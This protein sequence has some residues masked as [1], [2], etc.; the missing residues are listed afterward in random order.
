MFVLAGDLLLAESIKGLHRCPRPV[1]QDILDVV[2]QMTRATMLEAIYSR[3]DGYDFGSISIH[4]KRER[5]QPI[6]WCG[7]AA[8]YLGANT[9]EIEESLECFGSFWRTFWYWFSNG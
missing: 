6:L 2:A 4:R 1:A 8:A 5:R 7:R 3:F 9:S